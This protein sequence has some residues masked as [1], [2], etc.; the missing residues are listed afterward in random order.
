MAKQNYSKKRWDVSDMPRMLKLREA[1]EETGLSYNFLR[2][3]CLQEKIFYI[4]A[5]NRYLINANSLEVF[6]NGGTG[7]A[8]RVD[9][10]I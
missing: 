2:Q 4:K 3:L 6:L 5:G 8:A 10:C 1:A 9:S 7:D